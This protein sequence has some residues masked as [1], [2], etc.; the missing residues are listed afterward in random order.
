MDHDT[1]DDQAMKE[2]IAGTSRSM[3][4]LESQGILGDDGFGGGGFGRK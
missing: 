3:L 1:I 2:P 4:D